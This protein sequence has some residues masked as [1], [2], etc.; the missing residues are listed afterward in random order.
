MAVKAMTVFEHDGEEYT[1]N[2]PNITGEFDAT[3][4]YARGAY[5]NYQGKLYRFVKDHAAGAWNGNHVTQ[6]SLGED[7]V[8]LKDADDI[9]R[10][11]KVYTLDY[12]NGEATLP[13]IA[14]LSSGGI[15]T[16]RRMTTDFIV[17]PG[18][19]EV[20]G[21]DDGGTVSF[22]VELFDSSFTSLGD[23]LEG[24]KTK[25]KKIYVNTADFPTAKY[26]KVWVCD[27]SNSSNDMTAA[28]CEHARRHI[29]FRTGIKVKGR[30]EYAPE[31][32]QQGRSETEHGLIVDVTTRAVSNVFYRNTDDMYPIVNVRPDQGR[33][34]LKYY[35]ADFQFEEDSSWYSNS[36]I[37]K[38]ETYPYFKLYL[39][40]DSSHTSEALPTEDAQAIAA[41]I[42]LGNQVLQ[43]YT[44]NQDGEYANVGGIRCCE[45]IRT[46]VKDG[47]VKCLDRNYSYDIMLFAAATG[48]M[49]KETGW[50]SYSTDYGMTDKAIRVRDR[51]VA[52]I[53]AK[54]DRTASFTA[55]EIA[56][57]NRK[58]ESGELYEIVE[59]VDIH[60]IGAEIENG[61]P[62]YYDAEMKATVDSACSKTGFHPVK[63][64]MITDLHDNDH[65]HLSETVEKQ[66]M[67]IRDLHRKNGLDFVICGGDLTDGGYSAKSE[68]L[69]KFTE[70]VKMFKKIGVPVL[71]MRGNHDDNSYAGLAVSKVVS[72]E[73][74]NARCIAPFS[75]KVIPDGKTYYYQ[76]FDD[77]NTRVI[78]LDF[79]DYPWE[80]YEGNV[81]YH[82]VGGDG[83]WRG[84]SDDQIEWLLGTALDCD[85]RIIVTGHYSTH[86]NLMTAWEKST[87]HNYTVVNQAL[88]AYNSRGSVTFGGTTYSFADKTGKVLVQVSGHS[89]SFGAFK[90][91][92]IVWSTTGSP[93]PEVT[94]RTYDDTDYETMGTR[95]YGDITEAH[96]NMFVC[97]ED[98]VHI[99]SFGQMGDLDFTI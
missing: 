51:Y 69:D 1:I 97:D 6:V 63:F 41:N 14:G 62:L 36:M 73:E 90:D 37:E 99:I 15:A 44:I 30:D 21:D 64:A 72:R 83:V 46:Y 87:D 35:N 9:S 66:A 88:A 45:T 33:F 22:N 93:S 67:A 57:L 39:S 54:L 76:D 32:F 12:N 7:I 96:F 50:M 16:A 52:F 23:V 98:N 31:D 49:D 91:S 75:G 85:K 59:S 86:P 84:Y 8:S 5:V 89:H 60:A 95:T 18:D 77:V 48:A 17:I 27:W 42:H 4:A 20:F 38:E 24:L 80:V 61:Y 19:F 74:F 65:W 11:E 68:L 40:R 29:I 25:I 70:L 55:E 10:A 81:V 13:L 47:Y 58:H 3:A 43:N 28:Q 56:E 79:I 26:A 82:A 53:F 94:E 2:D 71:M 92:G 78:V 34:L